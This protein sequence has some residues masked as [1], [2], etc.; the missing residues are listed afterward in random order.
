MLRQT[1]NWCGHLEGIIFS[2]L[3]DHKEKNYSWF[4]GLGLF[5]E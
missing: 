4:Y 1:Q 2:K 3:Y 5:K